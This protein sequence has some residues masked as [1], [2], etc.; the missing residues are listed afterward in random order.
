MADDTPA[1]GEG[2][3]GANGWGHGREALLQAAVAVVARGGLRALTYRAVAAEAGVVHGLVRHH[4]GSRDELM[5]AATAT[6][7]RAAVAAS[8]LEPETGDPGDFVAG[9]SRMVDREPD[10]LAFQYEII[11][12]SRRRGDLRGDV[13]S[14]YAEYRAATLRELTRM[15]LQDS[16]P[17]ANLVFAA[18]DGLVL[19]QLALGDA[20][21][22]DE[23][24]GA[25]RD[26]LVMLRDAR[27]GEAAP[28]APGSTPLRAG[29]PDS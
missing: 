18:L 5:A 27:A 3:R 16:K 14:L 29:R 8:G 17:L 9:L 4:F 19:Q 15:G 6:S 28:P 26:I 23:A 12:E 22:T 7:L 24:L 2:P 13:Q 21:T 20:K 1:A 11:L 10:G 25:L